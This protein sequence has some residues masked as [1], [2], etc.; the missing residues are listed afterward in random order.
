MQGWLHAR[1]VAVHEHDVTTAEGLGEA[2]WLEA[3]DE[4]VLPVLILRD[5]GRE[6]VR[7][8]GQLPPPAE[9]ARVIDLALEEHDG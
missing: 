2:A 5:D 6:L 8:V 7:Y 4:Q 9:L 3:A 1:G